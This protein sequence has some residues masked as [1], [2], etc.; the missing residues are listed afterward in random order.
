MAGLPSLFVYDLQ[1]E[2]AAQRKGVGRHL[3]NLL[4][5]I[6][7]KQKMS[8]VQIAV[9]DGCEAIESLLLDKAGF[10]E[11]EMDYATAEDVDDGMEGI[12]IFHKVFPPQPQP[13]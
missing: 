5:L 9:P 3:L 8:V 13:Q 7:R 11:D 10:V 6:A 4:Q 12:T 1:V 2:E